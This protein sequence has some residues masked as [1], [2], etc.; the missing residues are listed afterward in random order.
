MIRSQLVSSGLIRF[1]DQPENFLSWKS[2]FISVVTGLDLTAHE[3][4]DLLIKWLG[5]ESS[6]Q[7]RR[8][9]VV[10]INHPTKALS[11]IW[12]RLEECNG[13]QKP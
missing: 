6:Q 9:K 12:T 4:I 5:P 3:E 10:N 13:L 1:D 11:L 8:M 2:T 7:A